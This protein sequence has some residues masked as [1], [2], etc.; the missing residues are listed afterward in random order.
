M[1]Q[2]YEQ[3]ASQETRGAW[4]IA[5]CC[6][7]WITCCKCWETLGKRVSRSQA[8]PLKLRQSISRD[9]DVLNEFLIKKI[10]FSG[11]YS[12]VW[13][14]EGI[15]FR[16]KTLGISLLCTIHCRNLLTP[17]VIENICKEPSSSLLSAPGC[18]EILAIIPD[19][20]VSGT[21]HKLKDGQK[22]ML[23]RPWI[24]VWKQILIGTQFSATIDWSSWWNHFM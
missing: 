23:Y 4:H 3:S 17:D 11:I 6:S 9:H 22:S 2:C 16:Y 13:K 7:F 21:V 14:L 20:R 15:C 5:R 19:H 18:M 10:L 8:K 1:E 24:T 12:Q